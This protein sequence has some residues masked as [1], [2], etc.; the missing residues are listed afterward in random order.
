M[1]AEPYSV[2]I[3]LGCETIKIRKCSLVIPSDGRF[4]S[5]TREL[6]ECLH[7]PSEFLRLRG[8]DQT[9]T[10]TIQSQLRYTGRLAVYK[11]TRIST[12]TA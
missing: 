2:K 6:I 7:A 5:R 12:K 11:G 10:I 4:L 3:T 8:A 9:L 1:E